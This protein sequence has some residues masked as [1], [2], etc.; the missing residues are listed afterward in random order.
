MFSAEDDSKTMEGMEWTMDEMLPWKRTWRQPE[1]ESQPEWSDHMFQDEGI[2]IMASK[3]T[4][5]QEE[6][7]SMDAITSVE[8]TEM[9]EW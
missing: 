1:R 4:V 3:R 6:D 7:G 8:T 5:E 2:D 9:D